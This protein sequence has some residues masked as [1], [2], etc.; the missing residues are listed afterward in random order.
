MKGINLFRIFSLIFLIFFL[1]GCVGKPSINDPN[2]SDLDLN[3]EDFFNGEVI[4]YGQFQDVFG[5][6]RSR[7]KVDISGT[8]DGNR[9]E[10]EETFVYSDKT[11]MKRNWTL[12]KLT[13][14]EWEGKAPDVLGVAK[15]TEVGDL[16][17][18]QYQIDLPVGD[19]LLRVKFDDWMWLFNDNKL[20]NK[21]YVQKYGLTIGEVIIFFEKLS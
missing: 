8:F 13:D 21:A 14:S 12:V 17:N 5:T 9:L 20:F 18:W 10:L 19:R 15:G 6:V 1:G 16:F 11:K 4:A 7:F 3:L 2:L